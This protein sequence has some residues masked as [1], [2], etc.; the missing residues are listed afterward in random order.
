MSRYHSYLRTAGTILSLYKGEMPFPAFLKKFFAGNKKHGSRDRK[1]IAHLCYCFFRTGKAARELPVVE[2]IVAGL[3]LCSGSSNNLLENLGPGYHA[4]TALGIQEKFSLLETAGSLQDVFP[5]K[6]ELSPGIDHD[7]FCTSFFVQ[8]DLFLRLRPGY[9]E[10]VLQ[11]LNASGIVFNRVGRQ[12]LALPAATAIDKIIQPDREAVIQDYSS[13]RIGELVSAGCRLYTTGN[14]GN[15]F[16][17]WDCCAGSGGKSIMTYDINP[18][19]E[20]T[21]SDIR[22]SILRNLKKRFSKAGIGNYRSFVTDLTGKADPITGHFDLILCDAPCSGSGTWGRTPEQLY[23]FDSKKINEYAILQKRIVSTILPR[24][25][26]GGYLLYSTCSV[27]KKENEAIVD[28]IL[29]KLSENK[30][31]SAPEVIKM[32]LF[33]GYEYKADTMFAALLRKPL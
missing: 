4:N 26:P 6:E 29:E 23:Y 1:D 27:F 20:L 7:S 30:T 25:K 12:A 32:D 16:K 33:K 31:G 22:E 18:A 5:W 10:I 3:F 15:A 8:P 9:E 28:F 17:V 21:V 19:I 2:R 13:Q 24:I 14:R 11:K